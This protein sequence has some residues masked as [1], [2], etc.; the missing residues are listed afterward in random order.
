MARGY[1][2]FYETFIIISSGIHAV[3]T[4]HCLNVL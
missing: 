4:E 2:S 1:F 3:N